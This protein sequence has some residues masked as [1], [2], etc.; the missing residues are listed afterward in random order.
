[1]LRGEPHGQDVVEGLVLHELGHHVYHR[2]EAQEAL[3]KQAHAEGLGH[4]L[5]LVADEHLERNLRALDPAYGDRLK[6]LGAFAF[7]HAAEEIAVPA[8]LD[9]LRGATARALIAAEPEVAFDE[10]SLRLRRGAVLSELDR[11]GHPLARFARAL[12]MGLGNR[13]GDPL[14]AAALEL[15]GKP[16]RRLDMRGLY[17]LTR[18]LAAMFGGAVS[19]ARVF[20]GPE[21]MTFGERD[22]DVHGAGLDDDILQ[23]EVERILEPRRGAGGAAGPPGPNDRL[24]INV[25]PDE[26][27]ERITSVVR[28]R[29]DRAEHAKIAAEV[30][31]HAVRLRAL[32]DD[33]GLR[34]EP[35]KARL[36][37]HALDRGRLRA[38]VTRG[39]P[40]IM[41]ARAVA[42]RTD[43][44]LGVVIDCS[45][46][47]SA[48]DNIDRARRFA[49][50][51][52]EAVRPLAGVEA[53][54]FGFTDSQI[55]AA[56]DAADCGVTAL[57]A[58]G[59]NNDAA[60]LYHAASVAAASRRRAKVLVM[61]SDGLP[62]ECSVAAVRGL[63]T[64]LTRR[65]GIVCAQVAVRPLEEVMFPHYLVLDDE[66]LD[67]AVARFGRMIGGLARRVLA[68]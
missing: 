65:R 19:V 43:L 29:G 41:T 68:P 16:L 44:F 56:G 2:G 8:L 52:T 7:H 62:T 21:G 63:V 45:G 14:V 40:R 61:I 1:M 34:R 5:N 31:R 27:F 39:D 59:G 25:G 6:R 57:E 22:L 60:G 38:L 64:A 58:G 33:L 50:L 49:I 36:A 20:G 28:V 3:W 13:S 67:V 35:V 37:G 66:R 42:R 48:G 47:M 53:R 18:Q 32:L 11:G 10:A 17:D 24:A 9:C 4:L 30:N 26:K 55:Y 23:R 15:C 54:V 12:R 51:V 46:S